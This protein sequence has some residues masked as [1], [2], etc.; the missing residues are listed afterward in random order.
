MF[1]ACFHYPGDISLSRSNE[2]GD[3]AASICTLD[4]SDQQQRCLAWPCST[5]SPSCL[6]LPLPLGAFLLEKGKDKRWAEGYGMEVVMLSSHLQFALWLS[7]P[8]RALGTEH[9]PAT[10]RSLTGPA[11]LGCDRDAQAPSAVD[12]RMAFLKEAKNMTAAL[13]QL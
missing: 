3:F 7:S 1:T 2:H 5:P 12:R 11:F 8:C 13:H 10:S 4:L 6:H 9:L